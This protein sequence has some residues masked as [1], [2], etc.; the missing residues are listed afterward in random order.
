MTGP[1]RD[2]EAGWRRLI[3]A[4]HRSV[5]WD[6][7]NSY[8]VG[9]LSSRRIGLYDYPIRAYYNIY[10]IILLVGSWCFVKEL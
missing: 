7:Y 4:A 5:V 2:Q 6:P 10:T 3:A 1:G 8:I 9:K